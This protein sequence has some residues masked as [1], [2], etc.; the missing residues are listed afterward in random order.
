M[1]AGELIGLPSVPVPS[2]AN[3][4]MLVRNMTLTAHSPT[5]AL[6]H[7]FIVISRTRSFGLLPLVLQAAAN[8]IS[9]V[10]RNDG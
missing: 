8:Q 9:I 2:K 7:A 6:L 4:P 3:I 5:F 1:S 10:G